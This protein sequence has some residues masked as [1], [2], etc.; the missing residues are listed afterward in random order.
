[1]ARGLHRDQPHRLLLLAA[2][3]QRHLKAFTT[4]SMRTARP[5]TEDSHCRQN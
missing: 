3:R 5:T 2:D 4:S 1:M